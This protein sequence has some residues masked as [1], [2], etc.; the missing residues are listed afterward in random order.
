MFRG[1]FPPTHLT[2]SGTLII[3]SLTS[4][5]MA[6]Q[7]LGYPVSPLLPAATWWRPGMNSLPHLHFLREVTRAARACQRPRTSCSLAVPALEARLSESTAVTHWF[8]IF[9]NFSKKGGARVLVQVPERFPA[10][11][12]KE[13]WMLIRETPF[14]FAQLLSWL[15]FVSLNAKRVLGSLRSQDSFQLCLQEFYFTVSLEARLV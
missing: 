11:G 15:K 6:P 14:L 13:H 5:G 12:Q 4:S 9:P 1:F 3:Y 7:E 2:N 10:G 8:Q